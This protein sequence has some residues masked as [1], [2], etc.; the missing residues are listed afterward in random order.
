MDVARE[1]KKRMQVK[2]P[3]KY[4]MANFHTAVEEY[5]SKR[6]NESVRAH[7]HRTSFIFINLT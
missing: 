6:L 4:S 1:E 5:K 7:E 2:P 3:R